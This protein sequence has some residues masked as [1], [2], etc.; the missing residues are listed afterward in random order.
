MKLQPLYRVRFAYTEGWEIALAAPPALE[1]QHFFYAQGT[2]EGRIQGKFRGTNHPRRRSDGTFEP[3]FQGVIET[4]DG[5]VIFHN[6]T[7]YGRTY[8][9]GRRQIVVSA[10]H[11]S[12]HPAYRWLNDSVAVG[13]GEVR[14]VGAGQVEL[15]C[16]FYETVWEPLAE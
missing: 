13:E 7:G 12:E 6:A 16:D 11:L 2:C 10:V 3:N 14:L 8:P 1:G 4:S 5:A 15:V 9:A